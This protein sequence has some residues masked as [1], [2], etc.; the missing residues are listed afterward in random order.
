MQAM[1]ALAARVE[2]APL[3]ARAAGGLATVVARIS[4]VAAVVVDGLP[5]RL[6]NSGKSSGM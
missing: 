5:T 3:V 4:A 1:E 6:V 2:V